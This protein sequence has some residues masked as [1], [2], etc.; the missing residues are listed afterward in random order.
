MN[1]RN[2]NHNPHLVR[3]LNPH[4][5]PVPIMGPL[6]ELI[7]SAEL[8]VDPEFQAL[9]AE[10][11]STDPVSNDS[12]SVNSSRSDSPLVPIAIDF[13][14]DENGGG[15]RSESGESEDSANFVQYFPRS[16]PRYPGQPGK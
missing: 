13:S 15:N 9:I 12:A 3:R 11:E 2:P 1:G 10:A 16:Y 7:I 5:T 4:R 8:A 6:D 14:S